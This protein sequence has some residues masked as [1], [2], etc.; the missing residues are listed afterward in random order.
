M[1]LMQFFQ[2]RTGASTPSAPFTCD[3]DGTLTNGTCTAVGSSNSSSASTPRDGTTPRGTPRDGPSPR[4]TSAAAPTATPTAAPTASAAP[5]ATN[6]ADAPSEASG[7]ASPDSSLSSAPPSVSK[8][9]LHAAGAVGG[10]VGQVAT[11][12]VPPHVLARSL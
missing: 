1:T 9:F 11:T 4:D 7:T 8:S 5:D 12:N 3:S 10:R 6:I 2:F